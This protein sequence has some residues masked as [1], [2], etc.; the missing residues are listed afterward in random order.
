ME[1]RAGGGETQMA[2]QPGTSLVPEVHGSAGLGGESRVPVPGVVL[3]PRAN[4]QLCEMG[5][6]GHA[7]SLCN[8]Q[9]T[10]SPASWSR[11]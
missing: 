11:N 2:Q 8:L 3:N 9:G 7:S 10:P 5:S 4:G 6:C 1:Q